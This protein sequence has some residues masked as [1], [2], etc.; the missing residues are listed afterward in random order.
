M[1]A[2]FN[3]HLFSLTSCDFSLFCDFDGAF[4]RFGDVKIMAT[5]RGKV[6]FQT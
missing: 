1:D 4:G 6:M 5:G 2:L 3:L